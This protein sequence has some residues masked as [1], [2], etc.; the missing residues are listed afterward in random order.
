MRWIDGFPQPP[1]SI[2]LILTSNSSSTFLCADSP[3]CCEGEKY[4][5]KQPNPL[6]YPT[7]RQ[8]ALIPAIRWAFCNHAVLLY[9][10]CSPEQT[11]SIQCFF[12]NSLFFSLTKVTKAV[13]KTTHDCKMQS[14]PLVFEVVTKQGMHFPIEE[15]NLKYSSHCSAAHKAKLST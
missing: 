12:S 7:A 5:P 13:P 10:T 14:T 11:N 6:S 3:L 4:L 8:E 2:K 1:F 9:P 15:G